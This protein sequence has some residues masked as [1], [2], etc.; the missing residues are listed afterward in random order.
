MLSDEDLKLRSNGIGSSEIAML[1]YVKDED[2]GSMKPLSP[3][4]GKHKLWV[5]KTHGEVKKSS[6]A[7]TRGNYL[8]DGIINWCADKEGYDLS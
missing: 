3:W 4:G 2:T 7:M 1:V 6:D 5:K 8:E